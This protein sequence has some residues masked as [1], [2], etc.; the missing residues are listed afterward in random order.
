MRP[1]HIQQAF[2]NQFEVQQ[3]LILHHWDCGLNIDS[4]SALRCAADRDMLERGS[5]FAWRDAAYTYGEWYKKVCRKPEGHFARAIDDHLWWIDGLE[6]MADLRG[7]EQCDL[8]QSLK[9]WGFP[10]DEAI[11]G[12]GL[13]SA[14]IIPFPSK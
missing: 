5:L 9:S 1:A 13:P 3:A 4:D 14:Q 2:E 10:I 12:K 8:E 7:R 6:R 11:I